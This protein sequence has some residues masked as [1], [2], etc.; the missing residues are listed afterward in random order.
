MFLKIKD[1]NGVEHHIQ[2]RHVMAVWA[3]VEQQAMKPPQVNFMMQ[4]GTGSEEWHL[5]GVLPDVLD[6][7]NDLW[8]ACYTPS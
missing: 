4:T 2:S 6:E 3:S 7:I 1:L 5:Q 8:K